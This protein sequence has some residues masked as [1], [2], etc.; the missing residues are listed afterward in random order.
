MV[1]GFS[2]VDR[3]GHPERFKAYLDLTA[4]GLAAMKQY[5]VAAHDAAGSELVLDI[6]C[7][8]GHD[9]DLL[10]DAHIPAL[11]IDPSAQ[12]LEA[13]QRRL[14]PRTPRAPLL[15]AYGEAIPLRD[16]CVGGCRIERVLQHVADPAIVLSEA[17]RCLRPGGLLTVFEPDW[18]SLRIASDV[19]DPDVSWLV[20]VKQP[21]IGRALWD[22][23]EQAGCGV[24]DR[25]EELSVWSSLDLAERLISVRAGLRRQVDRG[26]MTAEAAAA[27]EAEQEDRDRD[28]RFRATTVKVLICARKG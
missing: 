2:A 18:S 10:A 14:Q 4:R 11:G 8:T 9:L 3:A 25:V 15:R 26:L 19:F 7:G 22:L 6:G 21:A 16:A 23:V 27:R 17:V 12:L 13:A 20:Q 5:I 24:V 1:S 28:G